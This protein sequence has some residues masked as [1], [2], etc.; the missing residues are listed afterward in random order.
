MRIEGENFGELSSATAQEEIMIG[1]KTP[2]S[3]ENYELTVRDNEPTTNINVEHSRKN[4]YM[5]QRAANFLPIENLNVETAETPHLGK[6]TVEDCFT[7]NKLKENKKK[8]ENYGVYVST[9]YLKAKL[10]DLAPTKA[11]GSQIKRQGA[12]SLFQRTTYPFRESKSQSPIKNFKQQSDMSIQ[13]DFMNEMM[14]QTNK[15]VAK[16]S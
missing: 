8:V 12:R 9:R 2:T 5:S 14:R 1:I 11:I 13:E 16:V 10:E 4:S 7:R 3:F 15:I 6:E